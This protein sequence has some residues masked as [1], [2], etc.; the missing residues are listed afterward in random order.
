LKEVLQKTLEARQTNKN[1]LKII[2]RVNQLSRQKTCL[3]KEPWST[4]KD[5]TK[6]GLSLQMTS[7][8]VYVEFSKSLKKAFILLGLDVSI[9][10]SNK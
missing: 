3:S 6:E 2:L 8:F 7:M 9:L 10:S 1:Y 4:Y 5:F